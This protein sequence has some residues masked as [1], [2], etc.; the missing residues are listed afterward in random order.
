MHEAAQE[1][2]RHW[3][4]WSSVTGGCELLDVGAWNHTWLLCEKQYSSHCCTIS[5]ALCTLLYSQLSTL[6]IGVQWISGKNRHLVSSGQPVFASFDF[7][8]HGSSLLMFS[9]PI[10]RGISSGFF[11]GGLTSCP[12]SLCFL[13]VFK[14]CHTHFFIWVI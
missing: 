4:P 6:Y 5:T 3:I 12:L 9:L 2:Q 11:D 1:D 14:D 10:L 13:V 7:Q 8:K